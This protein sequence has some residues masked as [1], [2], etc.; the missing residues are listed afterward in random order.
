M[1]TIQAQ[2]QKKHARNMYEN[3]I[4]IIT[5]RKGK[6]K[7]MEN[8]ENVYV[9]EDYVEEQTGFIIDT[10][11]AAD[12]ALKKIAVARKERDRLISLAKEEIKML[13]S[14]IEQIE[15]RCDNDTAY[16]ENALA[17]Y[18]NKVDHKVT[19]T[20]ESYKL[21]SG[22]LVLKKGTV[23]TEYDDTEL[24]DWLKKNGHKD[25]VTVTE[26]PKWGE[27]KKTLNIT[28]D[29]VFTED[30]EIIEVIS[31]QQQADEFKVEV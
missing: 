15:S 23:K 1:R 18:F 14:S 25:L 5:C 19:K 17:Q 16:L 31:T 22:S 10:D 24:V 20:K 27:F 3:D 9:E 21:L 8:V 4:G 13:E 28:P 29:G 12:W 30:G 6:V 11:L 26:K 2:F 7:F